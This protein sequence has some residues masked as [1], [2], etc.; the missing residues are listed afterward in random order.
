MK[1]QY[2]VTIIVAVYNVENYI[3]RCVDSL[4]AQTYENIEV[5]LVDDGSRDRSPAI[6]D[7]YAD[8]DAR[9]KV[10]HKLNGGVS[11][12][13]QVGLDAASGDYIIYADP[14]DYVDNEMIET[15]LHEA[16]KTNAD[17]VTCD[18]YMNEQ[19]KAQ[20]YSNSEEL[21]KKLIN[22]EIICVCW[23]TMIRRRFIVEH[24]I[25]FT[26]D[27]LCMSEDFLF[28]IRVIS[29]GAKSVHLSKAFYHYWITNSSSLT[30]KRSMKKLQSLIAVVDEISRIINPVDYD[31]LFIRKRMII[32]YAFESKMFSQIK[33]LYPEI[34]HRLRTDGHKNPCFSLEWNL[35]HAV[36]VFPA[37]FYYM[38]RAFKYFERAANSLIYYNKSM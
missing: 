8:K 24:N 21:L 16:L 6:C 10:I 20:R 23:N 7:E 35:S 22:V 33:N 37:F 30:N 11:S 14:D 12:A 18:L 25:T 17:M 34:H 32:E 15:I 38:S 36:G 27:W 9:V 2:K 29:E 1:E 31:D 3:R 28:L 13:R 26:P 4:L 19:Y 5:L